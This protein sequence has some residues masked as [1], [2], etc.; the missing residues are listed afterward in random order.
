MIIK[1]R[2]MGVED[3]QERHEAILDAA[4]GMLERHP[5]GLANIAEIAEAAGLAK[6]T[7]YLYFPSKEAVFLG[8]HL[9]HVDI[10]FRDMIATLRAPKAVTINVLLE[11]VRKRIVR[12][13]TYLPL[14]TMCFGMME[15][16]VN[17]ET[18]CRFEAGIATR[19]DEAGGLLEQRFP[20]LAR[21]EGVSMLM[22]SYALIIGLWQL[23]VPRAV[24]AR[25]ARAGIAVFAR[26]YATE[27]DAAIVDL[28]EGT[29]AM[30]S[31]RPRRAFAGSTASRR[32]GVKSMKP[33][34][35][36]A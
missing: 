9:R 11:I 12:S 18:A 5:D 26:D 7:V 2:A 25:Q 21:G 15:R 24:M 30:S 29:L 28:W 3:K 4:E 35:Q 36:R 6:G 23:L 16:N 13:K 31:V 22:R 10:F 20:Q 33:R 17:L 34:K 14:A 19:L 8:L 1:V 32:A 27:L